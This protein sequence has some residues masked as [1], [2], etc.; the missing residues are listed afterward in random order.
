M[1][2]TGIDNFNDPV[3]Q[4]EEKY[5]LIKDHDHQVLKIQTYQKHTFQARSHSCTPYRPI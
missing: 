3:E 4:L 2:P 1:E 5:D